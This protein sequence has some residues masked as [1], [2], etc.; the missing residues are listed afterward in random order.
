ACTASGSSTKPACSCA[1]RPATGRCRA[2]P[3]RW[4]R[5]PTAAG[6]SPVPCC[7]RG[8]VDRS[9]TLLMLLEMIVSACGER[10]GIGTSDD[11]LTYQQLQDRAGAGA[12][13]LR[14]RGAQH[15]AYV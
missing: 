1:A 8:R 14:E 10:L 13:L 11:G 5:W 4:R 15:L 6:P 2:R 12:E 7:S 3:W 9:M